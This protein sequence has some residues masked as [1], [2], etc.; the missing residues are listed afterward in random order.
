M[1]RRHICTVSCPA[2][3]SVKVFFLDT[4]HSA[5]DFPFDKYRV[6]L[7]EPKVF[8]CRVG[9]QVARPRVSD[10]VRD[11]ASQRA[12]AGEKRGRDKR[13]TWILHP[14][15]WETGREDE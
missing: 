3:N 6:S 14:A 12:V 7:I 1:A 15:V 10:L 5:N 2:T 8:P 9:D 4:E 11:D 13:Q